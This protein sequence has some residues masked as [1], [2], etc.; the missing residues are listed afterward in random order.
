[1]SYHGHAIQC[2]SG[3]QERLV[4]AWARRL[5]V[6]QNVDRGERRVILYCDAAT[7]RRVLARAIG[8]GRDE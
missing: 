7:A 1:M 3:R 5:G 4:R 2:Y 8:Y 6:S